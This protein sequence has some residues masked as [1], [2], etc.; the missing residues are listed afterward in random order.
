MDPVATGD[1]T[2]S[3]GT[4]PATVNVLDV[5]MGILSNAGRPVP[6][7]V[8][9]DTVTVLD[10]VPA[11]LRSFLEGPNASGLTKISLPVGAVIVIPIE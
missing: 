3:P 8:A 6:L 2:T 9:P 4:T 1:P 5:P 10:K 11:I 7:D